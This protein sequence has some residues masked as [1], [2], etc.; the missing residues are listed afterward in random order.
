MTEGLWAA[1]IGVGG[2]ILGTLLGFFL[3]KIDFG[4]V[5][6]KIKKGIEIPQ[7]NCG[8][9]WEL[10]QKF[11]ISIYNGANKNS[12]FREAKI[13]FKDINDAEILVLPLKDSTKSYGNLIEDLCAA[14]IHSQM[15]LDINAEYVIKEDNIELAYKA[16]KVVL[17]YQLDN[18]KANIL[19][20]W[21]CDYSKIAK[22]RREE[23]NND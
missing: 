15:G 21:G 22:P 14:N 12:V 20:L 6:I 17:Q 2:T 23:E 5:E 13:I 18:S 9:L 19:E 4:K 1:L 3:G 8:E 7:Y 16:E 10:R 11:I